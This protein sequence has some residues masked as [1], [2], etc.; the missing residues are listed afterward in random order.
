MDLASGITVAGECC[1]SASPNTCCKGVL[2]LKVTARCFM[3]SR[4]RHPSSRHHLRCCIKCR[5][6]Q[7]THI[8]HAAF[9]RSLTSNMPRLAD[10]S[11]PTCLVWQI[12]HIQNASFGRSLTSN[13]PSSSFVHLFSSHS[14]QGSVITRM[15]VSSVTFPNSG[16]PRATVTSGILSDLTC[17]NVSR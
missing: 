6:W 13:M 8:Q 14:V 11:H 15:S 1:V 2:L 10:H 7:I 12:T 5:V 16:I 4:T 17:E 3:S 9:G